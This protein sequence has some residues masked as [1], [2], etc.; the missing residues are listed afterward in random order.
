MTQLDRTMDDLLEQHGLEDVLAA[1][2][3]ALGRATRSYPRAPWAKTYET[4]RRMILKTKAIVRSGR[5]SLKFKTIDVRVHLA[6]LVSRLGGVSR[7]ALYTG[8]DKSYVSRLVRGE[9][10]ITLEL[11]SK[12]EDAVLRRID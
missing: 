8:L 11:C 7:A 2:A 9:R 10:E 5:M 12:F 6:D 1:L 3:R 4:G